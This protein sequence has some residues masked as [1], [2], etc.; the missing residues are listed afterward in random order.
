MPNGYL[1]VLRTASVCTLELMI[2]D[3][4]L[5][6]QSLFVMYFTINQFE[7]SKCTPIQRESSFSKRVPSKNQPCASQC[8]LQN[9][10]YRKRGGLALHTC[11]SLPLLFSG[12]GINLSSFN[13]L[14]A[15]VGAFKLS[16]YI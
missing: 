9:C 10:L 7:R 1:K 5:V 2:A 3:K 12:F 15:S 11:F 14:N 8:S 16:G 4:M 6:Q 13:K